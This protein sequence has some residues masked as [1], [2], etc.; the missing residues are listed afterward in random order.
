MLMNFKSGHT[1]NVSGP[2]VVKV[3]SYLNKKRFKYMLL[4]WNNKKGIWTF[5]ERCKKQLPIKILSWVRIREK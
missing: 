1:P 2:F 3:N 4:H 5:N